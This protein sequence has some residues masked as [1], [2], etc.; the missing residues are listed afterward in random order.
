MRRDDR[1]A[2]AAMDIIMME[3][4]SNGRFPVDVHEGKSWDI[5]SLDFQG[6]S[7]ATSK[8]KAVDRKT[9]TKVSLT[10]PE[11]NAAR[12]LGDQH[13]L[14]IVR[15]GISASGISRTRWKNASQ[16]FKRWLVRLSDIEG[17]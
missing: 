16:E 11:W 15:L 9:R 10:D 7:F 6:I 14:Y 2:K 5:E 3:E 17:L 1:V 13:W 12:R 4:R 8:S